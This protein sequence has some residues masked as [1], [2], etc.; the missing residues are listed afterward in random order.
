MR[1][2]SPMIATGLEIVAKNV[3]GRD[4]K[5][6]WVVVSASRFTNLQFLG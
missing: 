3:F 5:G 4:G 1:L 2:K 6:R